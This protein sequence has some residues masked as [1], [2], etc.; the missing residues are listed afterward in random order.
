MSNINSDDYYAVLG[1]KRAATEAEIA[2][3]YKKLALKHHPDKNPT[4]REK[5]EE[6]F[7]TLTEAYDVLK[8]PE[9]RR[10]YDQVGKGGLH[11]ANPQ[12]GDADFSAAGG[13]GSYHSNLSQ[14][15]ANKIFRNLFGGADPF[16]S[17]GDLSSGM[18]QPSGPGFGGG[19]PFMFQQA[20]RGGLGGS[21]QSSHTN[22]ESL[23]N[24]FSNFGVHSAFP[25]QGQSGIHTR[26][27]GQKR[28]RA[29]YI[30]QDDVRVV[31][32]SL[33]KSPHYNGNVGHIVDWDVSKG[34]YEVQLTSRNLG[35]ERLWLR[36]QNVTQLCGVEAVGLANKPELN[37]RRGEIINFEA[38]KRRYTVLVDGLTVSLQPS[39]C[40]IL[41]GTAVVLDGL[42]K[43]EC[44]GQK[45]VI[46]DVD[47][48]VLRYTVECES[49]QKLKVKYENVL[50]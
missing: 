1:V 19:T 45:A 9:K 46:L 30:V 37:G 7:K 26:R 17:F 3:A 40:A 34:R 44:N 2:R 28:R 18:F 35:E 20:A 13:N 11:G 6:E 23:N 8:T 10:I 50:C 43:D 16:A 49:G 25:S 33:A 39:N 47:K 4:R 15:D 42:S 12:S 32:H 29:E 36:P 5:A 21:S 31:V 14:E 38:L 48:S 27:T 22:N 24:M 41:T